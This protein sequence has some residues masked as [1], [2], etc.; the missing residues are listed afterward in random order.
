VSVHLHGPPLL[1]R[2]KAYVEKRQE[3]LAALTG[4]YPEEGAYY[5]GQ[6]NALEQVEMLLE[7]LICEAWRDADG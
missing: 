2:L 7:E 5:L 6:Q 3:E 1:E 4:R